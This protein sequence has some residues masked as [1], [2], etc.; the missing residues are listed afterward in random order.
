MKPSG[1]RPYDSTKRR[2][3]AAE[4]R[5]R[6]AHSARR[7]FAWHG[8]GATSI[9]AIAADAAV[10]VPTF[11][12]IYRSKRALLFALLEA[13]EAQADV[14]SLQAALRATADPRQQLRLFVSFNC[15]FYRQAA[16]LVEVA[17]GAG[18]TEPDLLA[19]WKK[20]ERRRLRGQA[21]LVR[22]LTAL[23]ALREGLREH[24]ALDILWSLSGADTYRL[25]VTERGWKPAKYET[26]LADSLEALLLR[27]VSPVRGLP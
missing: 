11:Y 1:K 13:A 4:T 17:R 19:L 21:P 7:L 25:F 27:P 23:G 3:A 5:R 10:A 14:G 26:W 18:S 16:D 22:A 9:E 2:A 15:R 8:Y 24:D 12:A 6:I 20:G